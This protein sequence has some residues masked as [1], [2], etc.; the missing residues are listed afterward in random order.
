[1]ID[2]DTPPPPC[3]AIPTHPYI[4]SSAVCL[5]CGTIR[6]FN[7]VHAFRAQFNEHCDQR[8]YCFVPRHDDRIPPWP[9]AKPEHTHDATAP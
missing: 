7:G 9:D 8:M 5:K 4:P 3:D 2:F 6:M 1:M